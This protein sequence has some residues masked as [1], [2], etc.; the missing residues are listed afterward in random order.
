MKRIKISKNLLVLLG[1]FFVLSLFFNFLSFF[2]YE[3][4]IERELSS[5]DTIIE[6]NQNL[7][8]TRQIFEHCSSKENATEQLLC[9]NDYA[10]ANF[11]RVQREEVYSIDDMFDYGADCKSYSIYYATLAKMMGY[12]YAFFQTF[13]HMMTIAYFEGGYCILDQQFADCFIYEL[14]NASVGDFV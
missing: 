7:T 1:L 3:S 12:N 14:D 5:V 4:S 10:I 8:Y 9:V 6:Y 13:D 2:E 11:N